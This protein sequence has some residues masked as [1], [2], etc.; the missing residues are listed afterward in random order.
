M[1]VVVLRVGQLSTNCY[2]L[3]SKDKV[4]IIDPGDDGEYIISQIQKLELSPV[5]VAATHGHFDHVLAGMALALTYKIPFFIHPKD[6]FLLKDAHKSALHFTGVKFE[7]FIIKPDFVSTGNVLKVEN[8]NLKVIET[9]GHTPGSICLYSKAEKIL[10]CGDLV[11][12]NGGVGR[13]D[14]SYSSEKNLWD[15]IKKISKLP[16][17]TTIYSGHGQNLEVGDL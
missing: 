12:E 9:P 4:G 7:P 15:S 3:C 1:D 2:L 11:F 13:T 8:V 16:K 6:E 10:F 5:W 17:D 14:F